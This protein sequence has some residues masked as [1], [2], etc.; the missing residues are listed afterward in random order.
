MKKL[1]LLLL[2]PTV[3]FAQA[4]G[5]FF[6]GTVQTQTGLRAGASITVC[7]TAVIANSPTGATESGT[8]V[9]T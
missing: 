2:F 9:T 4:Q 8:T 7:S 6:S 3:L 1:L 5:S